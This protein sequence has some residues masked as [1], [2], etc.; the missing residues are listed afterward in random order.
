MYDYREIDIT[1]GREPGSVEV[2]LG[3]TRVL[4][5]VMCQVIEPKPHRPAEGVLYFNVELS[6]MASPSFEAGRQTS[7]SVEV[8]R[9]LEKC[10]KE[11]RAVDTESLCIIAGQ[12][13][14][15][16]RVDI[17]VLDHCGNIIDC[18]AIA[19]I[20]ALKH[21]RRPDVTVIGEE[22]TIHSLSE[23]DPV[24]L[25]VHHMPV[26]FS[27]AFFWD[28]EYVLVD[29]SLEEEQVMEGKL[30]V[31]MNVHKEICVL[32]MMGGVAILPEQVGL[33]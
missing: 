33:N 31:G 17:H 1:L 7:L 11:A 3:R 6:P 22:A 10:Q 2:T 18:A 28:G 24:P 30:V 19:S 23:R 20:T 5:C 15:E 16:I 12:K 26:C 29:P 9:I 21:F 25:S 13:V 32:Q 4:A 14:W 8:N 27:F